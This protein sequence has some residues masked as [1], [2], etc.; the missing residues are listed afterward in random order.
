M[1]AFETVI[2]RNEQDN[3]GRLYFVE[4]HMEGRTQEIVRSRCMYLMPEE[5]YPRVKRLLQSRFG[6]RH[7]MAMPCLDKLTNGPSNKAEDAEALEGLS[8]LLSSC[9]K[10]LKAI[11]SLNKI[12]S[13]DNVREIKERLPPQLQCSWL[14]NAE[15]IL[16]E[17]GTEICI[18]DISFVEEKAHAFSNPIFGGLPGNEKDKKSSGKKERPLKIGL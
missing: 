14:D 6:Q 2:E 9:A 13:P 16:I 11:G 3:A 12:E 7:S 4:Q 8:I 15:R 1:G 10:A 5:G 18:E 17:K